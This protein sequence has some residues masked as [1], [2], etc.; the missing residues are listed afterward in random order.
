MS[1]S[2]RDVEPRAKPRAGAIPRVA[3]IVARAR[4]GVIGRD[5][6][7]PWR[8]KADLKA[9]KRTTM[10]KPVLMGRKT[11]DSLPFALP[12]RPNLV[13]TRDRAFCAE[14]AEVFL[15]FPA[16]L[17]R[18]HAIAAESGAAEIMI[19]G[20][21]ALFELAL[22]IADRLYLTEV[23]AEVSGDVRFPQI[24]QTDWVETDRLRHQ[25]D[26]DNEHAFVVRVLDRAGRRERG[27][28]P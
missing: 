15:D 26:S 7:L 2:P 27:E 20:G 4:N 1:A 6:G 25:A 9:F 13:L 23:E 12:G 16:M 17:A 5:G 14:G 19:I 11:W 22:P 8:L 24:Q 21:E 3:L 28:G 18:A 10:G